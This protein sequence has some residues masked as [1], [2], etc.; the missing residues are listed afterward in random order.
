LI[1]LAYDNTSILILTLCLY[2]LFWAIREVSTQCQILQSIYLTAEELNTTE[3]IT[4]LRNSINDDYS[5]MIHLYKCGDIDALAS[6]LSVEFSNVDGVD[7]IIND[8]NKQMAAKIAQLLDE[9]DS[10]ERI[11][12]AVG[13]AHWIMGGND[14]LESLL[15]DYGYSLVHIPE[16]DKDQ[17][18]SHTNEYCDVM[19][20]SE[21]GLFVYDPDVDVP[22]STP[23]PTPLDVLSG[24]APP[25]TDEDFV[26]EEGT[27]SPTK[28][29]SLGTTLEE[30]GSEPTLPSTSGSNVIGTPRRMNF[31]GGWLIYL[32]LCYI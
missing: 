26:L 6:S 18:E 32:A 5:Q 31:V 25:P 22:G 16:W 7:F 17:V 12:F 10:N 19:L 2:D 11:L 9:D 8:R 30:E 3:L 29:P 15:L 28:M 13:T 24:N 23:A 27:I 4:T 20:D 1:A 21:T 14:S